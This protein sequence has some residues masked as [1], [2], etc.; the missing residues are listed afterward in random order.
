MDIKQIRKASGLTQIELA[1]RV[2]VSRVRLSLAE[3]GYIVLD[4]EELEAI[5]QTALVEAESRAA[6]LKSYPRREEIVV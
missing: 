6:R 3:C 5:K 4:P 2:K 1:Q